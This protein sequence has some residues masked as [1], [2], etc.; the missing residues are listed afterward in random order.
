M[1]RLALTQEEKRRLAEQGLLQQS[2]TRPPGRPRQSSFKEE[3]PVCV[4]SGCFNYC[5]HI[6]DRFCRQHDGLRR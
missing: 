1:N 3:K 4:K 5:D 6:G 2:E